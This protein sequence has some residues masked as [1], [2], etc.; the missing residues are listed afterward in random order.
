ME[1]I[2]EFDRSEEELNYFCL[3][4]KKLKNKNFKNKDQVL[5]AYFGCKKKKVE[6]TEENLCYI[7]MDGYCLFKS[8]NCTHSFCDKC[9]IKLKG[10]PC[11]FCRKNL[12]FNCN[13]F[14]F[15][16]DEKEYSTFSTISIKIIETIVF[17]GINKK[18]VI[19]DTYFNTIYLRDLLN[20]HSIEYEIIE[21]GLSKNKVNDIVDK[22][23][24]NESTKVLLIYSQEN[25][26]NNIIKDINTPVIFIN[27]FILINQSIKINYSENS[28]IKKVYNLKDNKKFTNIFV[29][30]FENE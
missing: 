5:E 20:K 9:A 23:N 28:N 22:F 19:Y 16:F 15:D 7:C 12:R 10:K 17:E 24:V 2:I 11:P 6:E 27:S 30:L 29:K 26:V 13:I 3:V 1:N 25:E 14:S 8:N 21:H 4:A 18:Y